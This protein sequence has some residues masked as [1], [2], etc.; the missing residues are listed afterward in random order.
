MQLHSRPISGTLSF[1]QAE[2]QLDARRWAS[3][4]SLSVVGHATGTC[5]LLGR[6]LMPCTISTSYKTVSGSTRLGRYTRSEDHT[7]DTRWH[8]WLTLHPLYIIP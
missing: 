5:T 4:Q 7:C 1:E 3:R 2:A 8:P 6:L